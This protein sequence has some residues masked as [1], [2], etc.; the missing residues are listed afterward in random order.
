MKNLIKDQKSSL[1]DAEYEKIAEMT[2][3]YS[4]ADMA[5]LCQE[6]AYGPIRDV[7]VDIENISLEDVSWILFFLYKSSKPCVILVFIAV[8][9]TYK[10]S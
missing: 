6:A 9:S 8:G 5:T 10:T 1:D 4:G 7:D 2:E 3:G